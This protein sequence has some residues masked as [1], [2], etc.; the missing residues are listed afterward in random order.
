MTDA[1]RDGRVA[2][3]FLLID[4]VLLTITNLALV[5]IVGT[6]TWTVWTRYVARS[7]VTWGEDITSLAFGWFIFIGM[8]AVH[9][10]R[11]HV[12]IDIVTSILP[13]KAKA[14][15]E[16]FADLFVAVFCAYTAY[17]CGEQTIVSHTMAHSPVLDLPLSYFFASLTLGFALM[18][19]RSL[20]YV[21]GVPPLPA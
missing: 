10:R 9:D 8:A 15:V 1:A 21:F 14:A 20:A 12:G 19:I 18:A 6:V 5:V 13:P 2:A 7:P 4:K 16:R 11:G 17:L 3:A